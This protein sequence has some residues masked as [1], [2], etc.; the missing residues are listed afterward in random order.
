MKK[1]LSDVIGRIVNSRAEEIRTTYGPM[2]DWMKKAIQEA[3]KPEPK[4]EC[5]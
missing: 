5:M 4:R 3:K 1:E 2:Q